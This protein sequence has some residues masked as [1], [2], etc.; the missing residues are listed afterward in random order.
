MVEIKKEIPYCTICLVTG[1]MLC[2]LLVLIGNLQAGAGIAAL[3]KSSRGWSNVGLGL[4]SSFQTEL[5]ETMTNV[6]A[7]LT[8]TIEQMMAVQN[9]IDQVISV[10]GNATDAAG[11]GTVSLLAGAGVPSSEAIEAAR[12]AVVEQLTEFVEKVF[13]RI[14]EALHAFLD[15]AEPVLKKV[16]EWV[17]SFGEKLQAGIESFSVTIDKVQ[18]IFDQLMEQMSGAGDNA[19]FM[20]LNTFNLFDTDFS[21]SLSLKD[22]KAAAEVYQISALAGTKSEELHRKY[23]T[24]EDL[25]LDKDTEYALFVNDPSLPKVMAVVLRQYAQILAQ[26][27]GSVGRAKMRDEVAHAVVGYLQLVS[28]KNRTKVGWICE[29]LTNASLPMAFTADILKNLAQAID[30]PSVTTTLDVGAVVTNEMARINGTH[31]AMTVD[32]LSQPD[33]FES[34]GF[35]LKDQPKLV[36]RVTA[37]SSQALKTYSNGDSLLQLHQIVTGEAAFESGTNAS[38]LLQKEDLHEELS[39][40]AR[41]TCQAR[42]LLH[43]EEKRQQRAARHQNLMKSPT[44]RLLF[45]ELLGGAV[46]LKSDP[47]AESAVKGGVPAVPETL[48]FA[49]FLSWNCSRDAAEFNDQSM[50]YSGQSSS[51]ADAFATKIKSM[52]KRVQGFISALE[53]YASPDGIANM[54]S[55]VEKFIVNGAE[56]IKHV[57]LAQV[58][59]TLD[60][61]VD[62]AEKAQEKVE[63]RK[64]E[65]TSAFN[66]SEWS[67]IQLSDDRLDKEDQ[68][69]DAV[70]GSFAVI[71]NTLDAFQAVLPACINNLKIARG[72]VSQVSSVLDS[73]FASLKAKGPPIFDQ[74]A[75]AYDVLWVLYFCLLTPITLG[76]LY[77]GFWASG[78]FGGPT[79]DALADGA[80][81]EPE[82]LKAKCASICSS[83]C[84]C[85]TG[86]CGGDCCFWSVLLLAQVGVLLLFLVAILLFILAGVKAFLASGCSQIYIL[87]DEAVCTQ[88]LKMLQKF[89][90]TFAFGDADDF[91][92]TKACAQNTLMACQELGPKMRSSAMLTCVGGLVG[93]VLSFQMLVD[94][95]VLHERAKMRKLIQEASAKSGP[96]A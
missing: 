20:R 44:A 95:S 53:E 73:V 41:Q 21:G 88:T 4:A 46:A 8:Q 47:A 15:K 12:A 65:A 3:G 42:S 80:V 49:E 55:K 50:A 92:V 38:S 35:D 70:F 77:Y 85:M 68:I 24:N 82:G 27:G 81:P 74:V 43:L 7:Q 45:N 83:C 62:M 26:V 66:A 64:Q 19:D 51:P 34:E 67:L 9:I 36:A 57:V 10:V 22:L 2:H 39:S 91:D 75:K 79:P 86:W 25:E 48:Q 90:K 37:W 69:P 63:D 17:V 89:V 54:R 6:T 30:D 96:T 94:S 18:K 61:A 11:M 71:V 5:D 29:T 31:L 32:L 72:G 13:S 56:E 84:S 58:N 23:D 76:I 33:F 87:G 78:W 59:K 93:A 16:G 40:R 1:A 52:I 60:K 14:S 28:Q